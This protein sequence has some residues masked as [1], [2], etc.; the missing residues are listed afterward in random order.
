[1]LFERDYNTIGKVLE[2]YR[3]G[4]IQKKLDVETNPEKQLE[5]M[6]QQAKKRRGLRRKRVSNIQKNRN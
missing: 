2:E 3:K 1:M 5:L 4:E 6:M